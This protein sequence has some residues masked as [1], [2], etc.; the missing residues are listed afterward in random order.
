ME[1]LY[2]ELVDCNEV[3][4]LI[5]LLV[6]SENGSSLL[7]SVV[8]AKEE[9]SRLMGG[10]TSPMDIR[11]TKGPVNSQKNPVLQNTIY[12]LFEEHHNIAQKKHIRASPFNI[13]ILREWNQRDTGEV[14]VSQTSRIWGDGL[15]FF[16]ET[17]KVER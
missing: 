15:P 14:L 2:Q 1:I 4:H 13:L 8:Q 10:S 3:E 5:I 16:V 9:T 7:Y 11:N 6:E 17:R 12:S